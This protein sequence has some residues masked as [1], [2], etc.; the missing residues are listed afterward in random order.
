MKCLTDHEVSAWLAERAVKQD[1]YGNGS[2]ALYHLQFHAPLKWVHVEAFYER[3]WTSIVGNE[4]E[5]LFHV[6]DWSLYTPCQMATF[7]AMRSAAEEKRRLIDA[8]GHCLEN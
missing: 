1:P 2:S 7:S 3:Y 6:T 4:P 5:S 8:P